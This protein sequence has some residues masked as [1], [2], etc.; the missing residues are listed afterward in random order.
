VDGDPVDYENIE[1]RNTLNPVKTKPAVLGNA[2]PVLGVK[3]KRECSLTY[4]GY[5][6]R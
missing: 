4:F 2:T 5:F 6:S 3:L 1:L